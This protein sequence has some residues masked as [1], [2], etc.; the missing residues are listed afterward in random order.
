MDHAT[1]YVGESRPS[2]PAVLAF[3][4]VL[5]TDSRPKS[6]THARLEIR[7][8][9]SRTG[10]DRAA[11]IDLEIA[12]GEILSN[13]QR[14]AYPGTVG[15]VFVE[16]FTTFS[17]V[18]V[19]II[20]HGKATRPMKTPA[21]QPSP[22]EF[23]GQ[24]LYLVSQLADD[25]SIGVGV[26]GYGLVVL[27]VKKFRAAHTGDVNQGQP[28]GTALLLQTRAHDALRRSAALIA[29]S[30]TAVTDTQR[31]LAEARIERL[32]HRLADRPVA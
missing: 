19:V 28:V 24:G 3:P 21:V 17:G 26:A 32:E 8:V 10:L 18:M 13:T 15:P 5:L 11:A 12:A 16:V 27:L 2:R 9:L 4:L 22:S 6:L 20:D 7:D 29:T 31:M 30:G 25:H 23:G 14:H 1:R